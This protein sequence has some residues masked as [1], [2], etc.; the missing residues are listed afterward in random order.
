[1]CAMGF[2]LLEGCLDDWASPFFVLPRTAQTS[3]KLQTKTK[4][5]LMSY[6]ISTFAIQNPASDLEP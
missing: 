3:A 6:E 5:V 4:N 1:V 2:P